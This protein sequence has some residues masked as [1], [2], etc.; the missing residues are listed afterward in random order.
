MSKR[1]HQAV[2]VSCEIRWSQNEE[3]LEDVFRDE[4]RS[5]LEHF[6]NLYIFG[7]AGEGHAV[8]V[9]QF[10][11]IVRIFRE[12]TDKDGVYP[13]VG[14]IGMST[15]QVVERVGIAHDIGFR[16]FQIALPPWGVL[17][18]DEYMTYFKDVCGSF[19]DSKFLHYNLIRPKRVLVARD[20]LRLQDAVPNLV[21]TKSTGLSIG[22]THELA[23]NTELQHFYGEGNF[24]IGCLAGE[25]SLLSSFGALFPTKTK[26]FFNYGATGQFDKLVRLQSEYLTVRSAFLAP[27]RGRPLIDG[28]FDKMIVRGSGIDMPLRLL[29]PYQGVPDEV[30]EVCM[31]GL[32]EQF[33]DW[34]K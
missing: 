33:P 25:S 21:A 28:A 18:D 12:E 4:V 19:P 29:S 17:N 5:T 27:A 11:R 8:T 24:P 32:R 14:C 15:P 9:S 16:V 7:T 30:F 26:E 13:M 34:L 1:Y 20:Y 23:S 10:T 3:L 31:K 2:L 6:D 22:E